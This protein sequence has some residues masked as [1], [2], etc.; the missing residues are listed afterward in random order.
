MSEVQ[1]SGQFMGELGGFRN[2]FL[3][4]ILNVIGKQLEDFFFFKQGNNAT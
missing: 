2:L 4:F 3:D 1:E